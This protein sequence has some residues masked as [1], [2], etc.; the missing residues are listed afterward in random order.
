MTALLKVFNTPTKS[1][2]NLDADAAATLIAAASDLALV[3]DDDGMIQDVSFHSEDLARDL[4]IHNGWVGRRWVD[5][6]TVESRSKVEALLRDAATAATPR[7]RHVNHPTERANDV[8]ILYSTIRI[9]VEG[10]L[11]AFG[12]DLRPMS[13]LQ[14]RLVDAQQSLEQ[15][16][17]RL[18]HVEMRYRL[19]FQVA[20]EAVL[21]LDANTLRVTEANPAA[22][23]LFG[24]AAKRIVGRFL[25]QA[26][27]A[28]GAESVQAL[29][30]TVR[31]AG[32]ADD[33]RAKLEESGREVVIS[34]SLFREDNAS[35]FLV[36]VL[37]ED[38]EDTASVLS[39]TKAKL[40]KLV[41]SAPDGF[42]VIGTD[43]RVMTAN[44]AFL[45]MAQLATEE[46]ARG[47][48]LD[49][50]LG[51]RGVD[52]DVLVS[53]LRQRGSVRLFAT[54]LRGEYGAAADVEVSAVAVMN[55]GLPCYGFAIRNIARRR[56]AEPSN[57]LPRSVEHLT[58]L[59]GRVSL[60]DLVRQSTDVIERLCI[61]TAL[62]MTGDNRASAAEM[63]GLSRQSFYVKLRRHG[64]GDLASEGG[65]PADG[66]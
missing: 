29:L 59:V 62:A 35:L 15:D 54:T 42:V 50:W 7:W 21:I 61:E 32:R 48:T 34:A 39:K 9:G 40:L 17:S 60:K 16:Y 58:E 51:H 10:R 13:E 30:T 57:E 11:V 38:A 46:Q 2:G 12:R 22:H 6:V 8:P 56:P 20:S 37:P 33:V 44:T 43:G 28:A 18:R 36:R 52:V 63:L 65:V 23:Q 14:Q 3:I 5:T 26:F 53:N 49:R 66:V 1:L 27:D 31:A 64:L 47:E 45:E 25:G 19:L 55:G 41:E 4:D 24:E